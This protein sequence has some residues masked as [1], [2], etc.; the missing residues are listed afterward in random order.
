MCK[1]CGHTSP[2]WDVYEPAPEDL[3]PRPIIKRGRPA[4][5]GGAGGRGE[6]ERERETR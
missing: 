4:K 5:V 2:E 1:G 6:R 3:G